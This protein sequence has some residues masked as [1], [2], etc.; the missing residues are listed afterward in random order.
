[1]EY[2]LKL[3]IINTTN[4]GQKGEVIMRK[5]RRGFTLIELLAVVVILAVIALISTPIILDI[6]QNAQKGAL[7]N[8]AYGI[9]EAGNFNYTSEILKTG[10]AHFTAFT[11]TDG[12]ETSSPSGKKLDYKGTRPK[13]GLILVNSGGQISMAIYNGQ[14]CAEKSYDEIEVTISQKTE[15][16]CKLIESL[17]E[18]EVLVVAG[19]GGGG[20]DHGGGGGAG[21]LIY[22]ASY[23][24]SSGIPYSVTI[25]E[26]GAG[27]PAVRS[28][29]AVGTSGSNSTF[30][31][32]T[33]IGG[34]G[35]G[36]SSSATGSIGKTGGSGGGGSGYGTP[37]TGGSGTPGQGNAGGLGGNNSVD[38]QSAG[39]GGA[40]QVGTDGAN[41]AVN[42]KGGDGLQ[43]SISGTSTWYAGG[44]GGNSSYSSNALYGFGGLGGGG[45]GATNSAVAESGVANTGG[46]GGG[47][48][49]YSTG[50]HHAVSSIGASGSGGSGIVIIRYH[51]SPK[52]TGGSI[53]S[54]DGYTIHTFSSGTSTFEVL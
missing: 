30:G 34:G 47:A 41:P 10:D 16:D 25:G 14:Y 1:M 20:N 37:R 52:A 19:G 36:G 48:N 21:G 44:G 13:T 22:N 51:G 31:S 26:G 3:S 32:L 6:I 11:Y 38:Y 42:T 40:S 12:V 29:L 54:V 43:F 8:T 49:R 4:Q 50:G 39:G 9:V 35:G 28:I 2:M 24:V 27:A 53:T 7:K 23:I 45:R 33:A 15:A 5:D 46:G 17:T 18:V